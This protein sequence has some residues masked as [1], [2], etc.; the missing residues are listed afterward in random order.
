[1]IPI[2]PSHEQ[3]RGEMLEYMKNLILYIF[4]EHIRLSFRISFPFSSL[5]LR[6]GYLVSLSH[7][8]FHI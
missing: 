5:S 1:M 7:E 3:I 8:L 6:I 4:L 2:R